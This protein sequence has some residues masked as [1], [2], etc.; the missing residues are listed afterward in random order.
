[1]D[2][3]SSSV[4][5]VAGDVAETFENF[6]YTMKILKERFRRVFFVPGNHDLWLRREGGLFVSIMLAKF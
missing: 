6:V 1:M 3:Y 5:L 4:L 2:Q